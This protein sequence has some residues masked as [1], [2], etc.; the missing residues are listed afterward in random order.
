MITIAG[1]T[2]IDSN[3]VGEVGITKSVIAKG[4]PLEVITSGIAED[5]V[6]TV[7]GMKGQLLLEA[8]VPAKNDA[9]EVAVPDLPAGV[10]I[11]SIKTATQ[12]FLG[13][14]IVK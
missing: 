3:K 1:G 14:F 8:V 2:D 7:H 6:F 9:V 13:Q 11:Y 10:Y 12:K 5:A 4:E